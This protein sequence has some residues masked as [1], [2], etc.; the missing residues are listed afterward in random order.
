MSMN[1]QKGVNDDSVTHYSFGYLFSACAGSFLYNFRTPGQV[2]A[3]RFFERLEVAS[4]L[5][6][7]QCLIAQQR[8]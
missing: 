6:P 1:A 5:G 2:K 4:C 8:N 3:G 7:D